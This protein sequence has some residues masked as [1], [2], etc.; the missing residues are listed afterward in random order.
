[1]KKLLFAMFAFALCLGMTSCKEEANKGKEGDNKEVKDEKAEAAAA[2]SLTDLVAKAKEEGAS[3]SVDEW[4]A[5]IKNFFTAAKP[6]VEEIK[7]LQTEAENAGEDVS[8]AAEV[9]G[10]MAELLKKYEG[11]MASMEEFGNIMEE[12]ETAQK[13]MED[14]AFEEEMKKEFG[15][16]FEDI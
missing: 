8:K 13:I 10:K 3:W 9:A 5:Q 14:K 16:L 12:N 7:A 2:V 4:K 11:D 6:M 15:D 1:M